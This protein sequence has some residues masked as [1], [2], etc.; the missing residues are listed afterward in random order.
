M[1]DE[2]EGSLLNQKCKVRKVFEPKQ[3]KTK[4]SYV[5]E[6]QYLELDTTTLL[7]EVVEDKSAK[8]ANTT[9]PNQN[10]NSAPKRRQKTEA[11][12]HEARKLKEEGFTHKQIGYLM[13]KSI[14]TISIYL[15]D[16]PKEMMD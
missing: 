11:Q 16:S 14:S 7:H 9:Q 4:L 15:R 13:D 6:D 3:K 5:D 1:L 8:E 2:N 12:I 10:S